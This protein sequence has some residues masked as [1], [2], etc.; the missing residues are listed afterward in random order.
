VP[1]RHALWSVSDVAVAR[2]AG[3]EGS[4]LPSLAVPCADP[5]LVSIIIITCND[6]RHVRE[7][8][9]SALAQTYPNCEVIVADDGSTDGTRDL[10]ITTYGSSVRYY[11]KENGGMGSARFVGLQLARGKY[12]QHL[13]S[14]DLLLPDKIAHHVE[15]LEA[16]PEFAFDYGTTLCFFDDEVTVAWEHPANA[17]ARSG[18]LLVD[19]LREGG[20]IN[21]CQP[22]TRRDWIDGIGGWDPCVRGCDDQDIALRLAYAG[23]VGHFSKRPVFMYRH[24]RDTMDRAQMAARHNTDERSEGEIYV[25][26]KLLLAM[27]CDSHP[28][29]ALVRKRVG[30]LHFQLGKRLLRRGQRQSALHH[31]YRGLRLNREGWAYKLVIMSAAVFLSGPQLSDLR[32]HVKQAFRK[33]GD[34]T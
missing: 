21:I 2:V 1:V 7:A 28:S 16:H 31:M 24:T 9:D 14:D 33:P 30:D 20:F 6:K 4:S 8:V 29:E 32:I 5:P 17:R 18:N 19:Y 3:H 10:V 23:A 12:I 11:W 15:Y 34:A 13:D 25:W 27:Q 22:L 26:E